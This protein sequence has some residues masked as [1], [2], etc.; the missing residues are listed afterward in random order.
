MFRVL[1]IARVDSLVQLLVDCNNNVERP[2]FDHRRVLVALQEVH[3]W[4]N[5]HLGASDEGIKFILLR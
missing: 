5:Q 2:L 1:V 4:Q 3:L